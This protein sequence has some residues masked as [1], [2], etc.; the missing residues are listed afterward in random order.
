MIRHTFSEPRPF[1][2][3]DPWVVPFASSLLLVQ[4]VWGDRRIV[5][6]RIPSL[7]RMHECEDTVIWAPRGGDHARQIWA[8]ELHHIDGRWYVYFCASDGA[9]RNHRVYVLEADNPFGPYRDLGKVFDALHDAWAIDLTILRCGEQLHAV[10]S[11]WEDDREVEGDGATQNLY[12]AAMST[13]WAISGERHLISTPEHGW[14]KSVAAIN[15]GPQVLR[16]PTDG[17]VFIV[18]SADASWTHE[19]KLGV[20]EQVGS[21]VTDPASWRKHPHP[22]LVGGGHGCFVDTPA[23]TQVVYHRKTTA[24][25]GWADRVICHEPL[26]WD[27]DGCP[28]V[29][30]DAAR[31]APDRAS[32]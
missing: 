7:E 2:G 16:N 12:I 8:P 9:N 31:G 11:G 1:P 30:P 3:Q 5:I 13:P 10:W 14:E 19:Y 24:E 29:G 21:D 15:E 23:G 27:A 20:L 6:R 18:Y 17:G 26:T 25:P 22:L 4:S 28:V 32:V